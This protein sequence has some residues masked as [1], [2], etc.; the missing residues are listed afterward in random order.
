M[1]LA[2]VKVGTGDPC[3]SACFLGVVHVQRVVRLEVCRD[4]SIPAHQVACQDVEIQLGQQADL[5]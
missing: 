3:P 5:V 2:L 1:L 4:P